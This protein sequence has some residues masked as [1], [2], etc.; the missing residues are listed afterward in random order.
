[1]NENGDFV[2]INDTYVED[3]NVTVYEWM[4][5]ETNYEIYVKDNFTKTAE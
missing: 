2:K 5:T 1:M 4:G 3:T